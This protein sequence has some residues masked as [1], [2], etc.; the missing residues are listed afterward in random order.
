MRKNIT[1]N[2]FYIES[3]K[4]FLTFSQQSIFKQYSNRIFYTK[5][6][7]LEFNIYNELDI[8]IIYQNLNFLE[9]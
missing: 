1:P 8:S 3:L 9:L 7:V 6:K 5:S 2:F 4:V